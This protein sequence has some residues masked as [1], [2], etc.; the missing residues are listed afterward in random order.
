MSSMRLSFP[1]VA[2]AVAVVSTLAFVGAEQTSIP[3]SGTHPSI[4]STATTATQDWEQKLRTCV[5]E[6]KRLSRQLVAQRYQCAARE[7]TLQ[8][9]VAA[10]LAKLHQSEIRV[11]ELRLS[12]EGRVAADRSLPSNWR[13]YDAEM[14]RMRSALAAAPA[15]DE[16]RKIRM[17]TAEVQAPRWMSQGETKTVTA[18]ISFEEAVRGISLSP[19]EDINILRTPV[20]VTKNMRV[21]LDGEGFNVVPIEHRQQFVPGVPTMWKWRVTP[22][23]SGQ[24]HLTVHA[25]VTLEAD[26]IQ[27]TKEFDLPAQDVRV[28]SVWWYTPMRFFY[29]HFEWFLGSVLFPLVVYAYAAGMRRERR[30]AAAGF[31]AST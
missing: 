18:Q 20:P 6:R 8:N 7:H 29:G 12:L 19:R 1:V 3:D 16:L 27:T 14:S 11:Q 10:T 5:G 23:Q 13:E 9:E 22:L 24:L 25:A 4:I 31:R 17:G 30:R 15:A 2:M 21:W 28:G 26:R